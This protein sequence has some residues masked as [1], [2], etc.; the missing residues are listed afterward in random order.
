MFQKF[1]KWLLEKED[2][3]KPLSPKPPPPPPIPGSPIKVVI[4]KN[5]YTCPS[6]NDGYKGG[7]NT[8]PVSERPPKPELS[9]AHL[10]K[11]DKEN[12]PRYFEGCGW[13]L[14]AQE[15]SVLKGGINE[16]PSTDRPSPP[17]MTP[18]EKTSSSVENPSTKDSEIPLPPELI[19]GINEIIEENYE[20]IYRW[21]A[22]REIETLYEAF[23]Y[24]HYN[25]CHFSMKSL[26]KERVDLLNKVYYAMQALKDKHLSYKEY[27]SLKDLL[28]EL[29]KSSAMRFYSPE[30]DHNSIMP[31]T[32][33][34]RVENREK[35]L[36]EQ[37]GRK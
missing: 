29:Y 7:I 20:E 8:G 11:V 28:N 16:G 23:R 33:L 9:Q 36:M 21:N 5:T 13:Y 15:G 1:L 14:P 12:T 10:D 26:T 35:M 25:F 32:H 19:K 27:K 30:L 17:T 3:S 37:W 34:D 22:S 2:T 6:G 24:F 4:E 18:K 31:F